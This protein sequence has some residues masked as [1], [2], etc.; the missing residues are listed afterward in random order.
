MSGGSWNYIYARFE[1]TAGRL[2]ESKEP[3][4]R[5]LSRKVFQLS[6]AMRAIEWVDSCDSTK[7][8]DRKL[9]EQFLGG[10]AAALEL[11][12][13]VE[14]AKAHLSELTRAIETAEARLAE[15]SKGGVK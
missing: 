10:D 15:L 13:V 2:L 1:E 8:D 14:G 9:I 11:K 5:A 12:E 3:L 7:G 4:R 6:E